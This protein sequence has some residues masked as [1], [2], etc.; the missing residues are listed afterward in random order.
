MR[1]RG[2]DSAD[3]IK[4]K[5]KRCTNLRYGEDDTSEWSDGFGEAEGE[6]DRWVEKTP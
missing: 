6:G 3:V 1:A 4:F 2:L 5:D